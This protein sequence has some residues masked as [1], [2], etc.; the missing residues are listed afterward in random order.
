MTVIP[1]LVAMLTETDVLA[2]TL[3]AEARSESIDG[4]VAVAWVVK[5]RS[6]R[7]KQDIRTVCLSP[8]QF[9]CWNKGADTNHM[10]LMQVVGALARGETIADPVLR[11]C[12]WIATGIMCGMVRDTTHGADHYLTTTLLNSAQHPS[13]THNMTC[14]GVIGAHTFYRS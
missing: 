9:S 5:N 3:W 14:I 1:D 10:M 2:V 11:E 8:M 13:W 7:R 12:R 6:L 4:R